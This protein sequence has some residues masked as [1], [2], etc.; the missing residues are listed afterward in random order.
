MIVLERRCHIEVPDQLVHDE[1]LHLFCEHVHDGIL[2]PLPRHLEFGEEQRKTKYGSARWFRESRLPLDIRRPLL[3]YRQ[4]Q[5]RPLPIRML[6]P[7][8]ASDGEKDGRFNV[9]EEC[10]SS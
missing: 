6:G 7:W 8:E 9:R 10:C 5:P 4:H 1:L 3:L 2:G